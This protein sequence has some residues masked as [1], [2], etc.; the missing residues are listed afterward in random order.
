MRKNKKLYKINQKASNDIME[1][2][3]IL[4]ALSNLEYDSY[5]SNVLLS[6]AKDKSIKIFYNV[7]KNRRILKIIE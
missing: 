5:P 6:M 4:E 3:A 2:K 1:L 7:E